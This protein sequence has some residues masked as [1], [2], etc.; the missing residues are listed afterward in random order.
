L[1][2]IVDAMGG[3]NAPKEVVK[4]ALQIRSDEGIEIVLVGRGEA[5][6]TCLEEEG[7]KSLPKGIEIEY[8]SEVV[9]MEDD[10]A[11]AV[12]VKKDSSMAVALRLLRDGAGDAIVS[13]GNTGALLSGATLIVKRIK[14]IRR[15]ALA[16]LLP[17]NN[18]G[19][20]LIDCGANT[21]CTPEYL[22]QFALMGSSYI[23][24]LLKK[25]EPSVA[26]L[27]IGGESTK[28]TQLQKDAYKLLMDLKESDQINFIGNIEARDVLSGAAD[29]V[30]CD[31][32]SGNI[33]LKA[34]EGTAS[35]MI[36]GI[37]GIFLQNT[38]TKIA[39]AIVAKPL[40]DFKK[41][42]DYNEVGGTIFLGVCKPVIK[43]HG[44]SSATAFA[45]A[46]RQAALIARTGIIEDIQDKMWDIKSGEE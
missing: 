9:T 8:A 38:F 37:K 34:I 11:M 18:G 32:F 26:L 46:I 4:G 10:P 24:N 41:R 28:G 30:V 6:L 17:T 14:G 12:R 16:P 19:C 22:V 39:A 27:N 31:G 23:S 5:I 45:N 40:K 7:I 35:F 20:L 1:K 44:S 25:N 29:V 15:A 21:E 36:S 33:L 43:A 2:I 13:A 3:D 42:L